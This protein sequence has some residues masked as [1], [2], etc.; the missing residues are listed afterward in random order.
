MKGA[1]GLSD[2]EEVLKSIEELRNKLNKI[3]EGRKL[4]DPQVVSASQ[5]LDALL[6]EYQKLMKDKK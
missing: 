1:D 6:N 4:T 5:M 2:L 3:A